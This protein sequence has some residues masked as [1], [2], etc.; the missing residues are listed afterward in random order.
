MTESASNPQT[1]LAVTLSSLTSLLA[2]GLLTWSQTPVLHHFGLTVLIG[3]SLVW[4]MTPSMC[5]HDK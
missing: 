1:W 4:L 2:F 5:K 3:L